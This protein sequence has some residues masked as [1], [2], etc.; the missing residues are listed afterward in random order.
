[1]DAITET[2]LAVWQRCPGLVEETAR[3]D[4]DGTLVP[5]TGACKEGMDIAYNGIWGYGPLLVSLANTGEPLFLKNRSANRP[6]HEGAVP[7]STRR[8]PCAGGPA[9]RTSSCVATPTSRWTTAWI[10]GPRRACASSSGMTPRRRWCGG[11]RARRRTCT[12]RWCGGPSGPPD[13][14]A[15]A[16]RARQGPH[17]PGARLHE[18]H[19]RERRAGGFRL[20]THDVH[21][22][23]PGRRAQEE[24]VRRAGRAR[25]F[26]EIR[27]CF[28]I[29][30]D[31]TCRATR[32]CARPGSA[33]TRRT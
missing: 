27:Y 10:A 8:S 11:A 14:P 7:Y 29:T 21:A 5:T 32:S 3:I 22:A 26:D 25:L 15:P 17:R 16:S 4:G 18:D 23:L 24:S 6:S 31:A 30:N 19:D 33:V 9:S 20:P 13:G 28:Y 1:M 2:R 12:T